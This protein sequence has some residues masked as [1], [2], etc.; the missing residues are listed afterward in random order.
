MRKSALLLA[1]VLVACDGD[2]ALPGVVIEDFRARARPLTCELVALDGDPAIAELRTVSDTSWVILDEAQRLVRLVDDGMRTLWELD[3]EPEGPLGLP[4][5]AGVAVA[6]DT[7]VYI[8]DRRRRALVILDARTRAGRAVPLDFMPGGVSALPD[9]RAVVTA[10]PVGRHPPGL[11]FMLEG[12]ALQPVDVP[13]RT[14]ADMS[15]NTIGNLLLAE[16][17][18]SGALVA[19]HQFM[20]PRAFRIGPA[21]AVEALDPP[22]PDG[23]AEKRGYVPLPPITDENMPFVYVGASAMAMDR[24][25][26]DVFVLTQTG[27]RVEDRSERAIMHL[28]R[29]LGFRESYL[30]DM[31]I[32]AGHLAFLSR[33]GALVLGDDL[34]RIHVCPLPSARPAHARAPAE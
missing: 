10:M 3:L 11:V 22:V 30:V 9:G 18:A 31:T 25:S 6:G 19:I 1:I 33:R 12:D 34:D 15:V 23:T 32:N 5:P 14:Y 21:G 17:D 20:A 16:A 13:Q 24:A 29:A 26:G 8:V 7:T 28:D 4:Y 27:R 2:N